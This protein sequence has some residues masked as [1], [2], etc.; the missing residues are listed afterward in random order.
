MFVQGIKTGA[1]FFAVGELTAQTAAELTDISAKLDAAEFGTFS[2]GSQFKSAL[3]NLKTQVT[4]GFT[5][6]QIGGSD[7]TPKHTIDDI[8]AKADALPNE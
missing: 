2:V 4:L 3:S 1:S 5:S 8:V 6:S 7:Q